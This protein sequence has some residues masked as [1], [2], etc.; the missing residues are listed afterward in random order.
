[1]DKLAFKII[2]NEVSI[3]FFLDKFESYVGVRLPLEYAVRNE[4]VGIFLHGKLVGGYILVTKPDFR[5]LLFIPDSIRTESQLFE[6]DLYEMMEVNGLWIG[7]Q[8]KDSR[9]QFTIWMQLMLDLL[10]A[11]KHYVLLMCN[12]QNKNIEH[13]H[14]LT[15]PTKLYEGLPFPLPG[16]K[17][18]DLI[19]VSYTTRWRVLCNLPSYLMEHRSRKYRSNIDSQIQGLDGFERHLD[20]L[21]A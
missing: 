17:S 1:M 14:N 7:P 19:R 20:F 9:M 12:A 2:T 3:N 11:K 21:G 8:I 16:D 6:N 13:I 4:V 5:S 18:H 10:V 15:R